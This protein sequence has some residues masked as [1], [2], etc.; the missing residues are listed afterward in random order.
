[1]TSC[2]QTGSSFQVMEGVVLPFTALN[3][4]E[5]TCLPK[6]FQA[7]ALRLA[8]FQ[9]RIVHSVDSQGYRRTV[10]LMFPTLLLLSK[11]RREIVCSPAPATAR[12][13]E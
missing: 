7:F 4:Y 3:G 8:P 12:F 10:K 13:S 11:A 9:H 5:L 1:M 2:R 6:S